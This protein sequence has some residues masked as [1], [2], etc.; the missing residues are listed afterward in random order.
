MCE[1]G[2]GG[3]GGGGGGALMDCVDNFGVESVKCER[4]ETGQRG[5]RGE[6]GA[7]AQGWR[8]REAGLVPKGVG[9]GRGCSYW[10]MGEAS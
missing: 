6:E 1:V 10:L 7:L 3:G 9:S 2:G 8:G 5:G 4:V